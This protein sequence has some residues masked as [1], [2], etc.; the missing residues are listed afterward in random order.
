MIDLLFL[1]ILL[2][3]S[4]DRDWHVLHR[5]LALLR[6]DDD[7]IRDIGG[8]SALGFQRTAILLDRIS[9]LRGAPGLEAR[10]LQGLFQRAVD[11]HRTANGGRLATAY[12]G[13]GK[14]DLATRLTADL[15]QRRRERLSGTVELLGLCRLRPNRAGQAH[16]QRGNP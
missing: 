7:F 3:Q 9:A 13:G 14:D 5:F 11:R 2:R 8:R 6:G 4:R 16:R 1:Q 15:R 10:A 12:G